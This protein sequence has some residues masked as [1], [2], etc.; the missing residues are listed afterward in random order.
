MNIGEAATRSGVSAKMIRYYES[1]G[2]ITAP[3]RTAAQYRVYAADDVHTLRFVR[4]SRDLGFSLEETRELL[5]LWRDK[6]RASAD[7]KSLAMAHVRELEE[8]AAELKAMAD[9]LRHLATH[10]HGDHRPDC[11]ILADFAATTPTQ[12]K[13]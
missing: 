11:P 10:C 9:T 4:R 8:K 3:A 6:S 5:A 2:L 12:G 1:I 7:V 13:A